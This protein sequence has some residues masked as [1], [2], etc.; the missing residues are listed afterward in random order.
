[1]KRLY[2]IPQAGKRLGAAIVVAGLTICTGCVSTRSAEPSGEWRYFGGSKRFDRYSPLDQID[3]RN[4]SQLQTA[5]TRPSLDASITEQFPDLE[6]SPYLR[7]TPIMI[8]GVLYASNGVGLV[9]AFD[10]QTGKTL[11]VQK[12]FAATMKEAAGQ[13]TRGVDYWVSGEDQR[14]VS[15]RG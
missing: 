3:G 7:S 8:D 4:V 11:W 2:T 5:W 10:A 6:A 15:V 13:S 9:E 1:M 14:I 12:P